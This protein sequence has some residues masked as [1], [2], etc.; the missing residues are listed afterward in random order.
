MLL[1]TLPLSVFAEEISSAVEGLADNDNSL[2][3]VIVESLYSYHHYETLPEDFYRALPDENGVFYFDITLEDMEKAPT[4]GEEILVYYRTVDDTAVSVWGDYESVGVHGDTYVTL[5]QANGYKARVMVNSTVL[6]VASRGSDWFWED[7]KSDAL[8]SYRFIFELIDVVGNAKLYEPDPDTYSGTIADRDK[9]RLYCYLRAEQYFN[10]N[11]FG[12]TFEDEQAFVSLVNNT[13]NTPFIYYQGSQSG[14]LNYKLPNYFRSLLATGKYNLG[15]SLVGLCQ[16]DLWNNEGPVT[17]DLYYT[18]QGEQKKALTLIIEGQFDESEFFGWEHAFDYAHGDYGDEDF[19]D[20]WLY[21]DMEYDIDD[22]IEDNFYGFILYDNDGNEAYRVMKEEGKDIDDLVAALLKCEGDGYVSEQ[23]HHFKM[24][25]TPVSTSRLHWLKMPTNFAYADSYSWTFTTETFDDWDGRRLKDVMFAFCLYEKEDW[26]KIVTDD[27]GNQMVITNIDTMRKG[28]PLKITIKV[29][30]LMTIS[31]DRYP[32]I[33]TAKINGIYDVTLNMK[34]LSYNAR[35]DE[36][37][38]SSIYY[39]WDTFVFEGEI[40]KELDGIT[41]TSLEDITWPGDGGGRYIDYDGIRW[42]DFLSTT[43]H[44]IYGFGRDL[45]T[46]VATV[47]VKSSDIWSK[48]K[49]MDI[50]V[51]AQQNLNSRFNDYVNVYYQD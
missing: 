37:W 46:P 25:N 28:D 45:R 48:S 7:P 5:N 15:V 20:G 11:S 2:P 44:D 39:S 49:S 30:Q 41:I 43:I 47:N 31:T 22:F 9:S 3:V 19:K 1:G 14:N 17:F 36:D 10:Q 24:S 42:Y 33:I 8:V 51:N 38:R 35:E 29:S 27:L 12:H 23:Y 4:N 18:Y 40:P 6:P 26:A 13:I 32:E 21:D 16:E 50:Y 34:Q